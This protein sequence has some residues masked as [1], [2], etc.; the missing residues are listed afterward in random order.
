ML[1][2]HVIAWTLSH[3]MSVAAPVAMAPSMGVGVVAAPAQLGAIVARLFEEPVVWAGHQVVEGEK[4][5]PVLGTLETRMDTYTLARVRRSGE[6]FVVEQTAC[7][8]TFK[9]VA[10][11]KIKMSTKH[12][13]RTQTRFR[14]DDESGSVV[15]GSVV[16]W[17]KRDIDEDGHPGM[18]IEVDA[19]MCGGTLHVANSSKTRARGRLD[20]RDGM[21]G[22]VDVVVEQEVLDAEGGCLSRMAKDSTERNTGRF[23]FTRVDASATCSSLAAGGWPVRAD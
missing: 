1:A 3:W 11:T 10:G 4:K 17:G 12:L 20:G 23:A 9:K 8:V 16:A 6:G 2:S 18:A 13:P 19:P 22:T 5:V 15:G 21:R 14:L 7:R